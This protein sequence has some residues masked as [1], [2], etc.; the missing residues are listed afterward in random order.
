[1]LRTSRRDILGI[2]AI[3]FIGVFAFVFFKFIGSGALEGF[4]SNFSGD[5][6]DLTAQLGILKE[7]ARDL[8]SPSRKPPY[9]VLVAQE[10]LIQNIPQVFENYQEQDW[11][12]FWNLI[13]VVQET[14]DYRADYS[15]KRKRQLSIGE[16]EQILIR[17]YPDIFDRFDSRMWG[18]FWALVFKES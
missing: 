2:L 18:D 3:I 4:S 8:F 17:K 10:S 1:M 13:Y 11:E 16:I 6:H 9:S 7:N 15:L 5:W 14:D 12:D